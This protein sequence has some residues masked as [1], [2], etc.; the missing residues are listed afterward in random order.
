MQSNFLKKQVENFLVCEYYY[1]EKCLDT[2]SEEFMRIDRLAFFRKK[3]FIGEILSDNNLLDNV[4]RVEVV[5]GIASMCNYLASHDMRFVDKKTEL[6]LPFGMFGQIRVSTELL[7][8]CY[9]DV[10]AVRKNFFEQF[11]LAFYDYDQLCES[12]LQGNK[13]LENRSGVV[14]DNDLNLHYLLVQHPYLLDNSF[15]LNES[16][17]PQ[18]DE[19][20]LV[21]K[22]NK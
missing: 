8:E 5:N 11:N 1:C 6:G 22:K 19:S 17:I 3:Q 21:N 9:Y 12:R 7:R 16:F 4:Y 20:I 18:Y 13:D 10:E 2:N 14:L 15:I